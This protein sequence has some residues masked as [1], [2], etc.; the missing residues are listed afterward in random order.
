[1]AVGIS[2]MVLEAG[3]VEALGTLRGLERLWQEQWVVQGYFYSCRS[4]VTK[5]NHANCIQKGRSSLPV[6]SHNC[7]SDKKTTWSLTNPGLKLN[8]GQWKPIWAEHSGN[9]LARG[10]TQQELIGV[11]EFLAQPERRDISL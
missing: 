8:F 2:G 4:S 9:G 6:V 11:R 7:N 1:M 5:K 10:N 3:V